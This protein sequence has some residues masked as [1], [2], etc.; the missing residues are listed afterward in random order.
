VRD[1]RRFQVF[2]QLGVF[3]VGQVVGEGAV[4]LAEQA[5]HLDAERFHE[6]GHVCAAEA[7]AGVNHR[8]DLAATEPDLALDRL[9]VALD[10]GQVFGDLPV[11]DVEVVGLDHH[12]QGLDLVAIERQLAVGQLDAV[13]VGVEVAAG[14]HHPAGARAVGSSGEVHGGRQDLADVGDVDAA[15][16]YALDQGG[17]QGGGAFPVVAAD[18]NALDVMVALHV[19]AVG[20][21]DQPGEVRRQVGI[22]P[23]DETANIVLAE[24]MALDLGHAVPFPGALNGTC[25]P[26]F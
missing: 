24:D 20:S 1:H 18:I 10:H 6:G 15:G 25:W 22:D 11:A 12:A 7:I 21:A 23:G 14:D 2:G 17:A 8:L 26:Q 19:R 13:V 5:D 9:Q 3:G 16:G 4:R